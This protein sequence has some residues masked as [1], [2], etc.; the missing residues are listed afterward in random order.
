MS[1]SQRDL[2]NCQYDK[3]IGSW[4][5]I[6]INVTSFQERTWAEPIPVPI[7]LQMINNQ[8]NIFPG[9]H[10]VNK[11]ETP[12]DWIKMLERQY[13][14]T[15]LKTWQFDPGTYTHQK[16]DPKKRLYYWKMRNRNHCN[17]FYVSYTQVLSM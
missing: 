5:L 16:S 13:I 1:H 14:S 15:P 3:P 11:K 7:L 17:Y 10:C 12:G 4:K 6:I 9:H 8:P 2:G